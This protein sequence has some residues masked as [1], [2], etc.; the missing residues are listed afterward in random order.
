MH[1]Q[2]IK[3]H[4]KKSYKYK[5]AWLSFIFLGIAST[6]WFL[7]RV[8]PKPGRAGYPC[9]R[10]A[11][12]FMSSFI[13]WLTGLLASTLFFKQSLEQFRRARVPLAAGLLMAA[14]VSVTFTANSRINKSSASTF[15]ATADDFPA[16]EPFGEA[17]GIFPGRVVWYWNPDATN[18]ASTMTVNGD[19]IVDDKDDVFYL[20]KNNNEE[21][22][23]AMLDSV[24]L[25][26]TGA[27]SIAG[28]WDSVFRYHNRKVNQVDAGY[29]AGEKI[30]IKTNNQGI[31]LT[32]P[33]YEDLSQ[34]D[35]TVWG[36]FPIHM[37]ATSPY[38]I[39]ATLKH[40]VNES[41]IPQENI[42]IGDPHNNF[43]NIYYDIIR[44][45]FDSVHIIGI[46]SN[47]VT[48]CEAYGRTLSVKG[49]EDEVFY[50]DKGTLIDGGSD[51]Y[52]QQLVDADYII[53]IAA[54]KSHIR[55]GI[56]LF[57]KSHFG[58][59]TRSS[60]EHLHAGLVA[61][62]GDAPENAGYGKY[63]VLTDIMGHENLGGKRIISIL[64]ALWG[65][66]PHELYEPRKWDMAPFHGDWT[67][68]LF[69]SLDPVAISSVAHDFLRIEYNVADW[70][71]EA[72][73][74]ILGVDDHLHQAAD[75]LFWPEGITYDP[76]NDGSPLGSLGT[77]EHW[78]NETEMLYSRNLDP[79][80]GKGIELV[81]IHSTP[82]VG[83]ESKPDLS[84]GFTI[85]P[86]PASREAN[87]K[88]D[89][90]YIG[91]VEVGVFSMNG[92]EVAG[93]SFAKATRYATHRL[94][95]NDLPPG[96]YIITVKMGDG[97]QS[98]RLLITP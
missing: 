70:G 8:I 20:P 66:P 74:N 90:G 44:S 11:A 23:D 12:P 78:N 55:G 21:V 81:K 6:A 56:T 14:V 68:S 91:E 62:E 85:Y 19:G 43:N 27:F 87:L 15:Q 48:D 30:Y 80:G 98:K 39:L 73:P 97:H 17:R 38:S 57:C 16:N 25:R 82:S 54:L 72:Y 52:Y 76:E 77:H 41:G 7:I 3:S 32:F 65:G 49:T 93:S 37:T 28:A 71:D 89:N 94:D 18:E 42:Y 60:A 50:S 75:S 26:L 45:A 84:N 29:G 61:P 88:L 79:A 51:K 24:M 40:L 86:N 1:S 4:R 47:A 33:M 22:I 95:L 59:H 10:A 31:G 83:I 2:K 58:S 46:N 92:Q 36:R 64:D 13:L 35:N 69:V 63:R 5:W 96:S 9:M 53:N 34:K 67:S